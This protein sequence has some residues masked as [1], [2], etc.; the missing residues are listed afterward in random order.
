MSVLITLGSSTFR[1]TG[2]AVRMPTVTLT[3][4]GVRDGEPVGVG[5]P[6]CGA[7]YQ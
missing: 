2:A 5:A 4:A 7:V 1:R 6:R 3:T